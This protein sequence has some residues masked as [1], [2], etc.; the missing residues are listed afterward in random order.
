MSENEVIY[1]EKHW[2]CFDTESYLH[3][4]GNWLGD[5]IQSSK[6]PLMVMKFGSW[7]VLYPVSVTKEEAEKDW[8]EFLK[9][10]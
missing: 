7:I 3:D 5:A 1:K 2:D 6:V 10:L 4:I 9:I 8:E